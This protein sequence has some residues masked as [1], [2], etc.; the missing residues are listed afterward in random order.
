M[1]KVVRFG[2]SLK[3]ALLAALDSFSKKRKF[4][5]RS[6][7]ISFIVEDALVNQAHRDNREVCGALVLI[8][9]HHKPDFMAKFVSI[10]HD[11]SEDNS[12]EP[13]YPCRSSYLS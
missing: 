12:I 2:V 1:E 5:S 3:P 13:A 10:Q 8:Y 6:H 4:A 9:D 11:S 7:A